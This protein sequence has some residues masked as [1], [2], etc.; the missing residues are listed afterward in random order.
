MANPKIYDVKA[1]AAENFLRLLS[2]DKR[3]FYWN[4]TKFPNDNIGDN[5]F[6]IDRNNGKALFTE[7]DK[8]HIETDYNSIDDKT[9]FI[10]LDQKYS[11]QKKWDKFIRFK[12]LYL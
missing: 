10:D 3:F 12:I 5:V 6:V 8:K 4:D 11:A 9:E 2:N 1:S 7:I